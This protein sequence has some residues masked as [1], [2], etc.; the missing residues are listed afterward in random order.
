MI[1][2]LNK[3]AQSTL[4][5]AVV[6]AIIVGGLLAMQMYIKRGVQGRL[7]QASDDIGDQ[8]SP[9]QSESRYTTVVSSSS[10]EQTIGATSEDDQEV[11]T[12]STSNQSQRRTGFEEI[13]KLDTEE[14]D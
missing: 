8:Y 13:D 9:G 11:K 2:R 7:K 6:I 12:T 3:R 10:D 5:Y 4:E 1:K 14:W